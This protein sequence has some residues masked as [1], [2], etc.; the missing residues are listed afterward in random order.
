MTH[1]ES[2]VATLPLKIGTMATALL[3]PYVRDTFQFF[4]PFRLRDGATESRKQMNMIFCSAYEDGRAIELLR[5]S[6]EVGVQCIAALF[7]A[8]KRSAVF[9]RKDQ[10]DVNGREGLRHDTRMAN[11]VSVRH[12]KEIGPNP[13]GVDTL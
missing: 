6:P 4:N 11:R 1:G 12:R 7:V 3:D 9:R 2:G 8:Q 5:D 13:V 10:M